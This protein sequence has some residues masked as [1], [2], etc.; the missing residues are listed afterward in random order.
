MVTLLFES[1]MKEKTAQIKIF[2]IV[3][4]VLII[5]S[6]LLFLGATDITVYVT[7]SG[8][9]YHR[10][11]CGSL[12][13]SKIAVTLEDAV[14]SGYTP[15]SVCEPPVLSNTAEPNHPGELYRVNTAN[16]AKTRDAQTARMVPAEVMGHID[17]DTVRVRISN[18]HPDLKTL[19]TIRMIGVDTPETVHPHKPVEYFGQEASNFTKER[20]LG[21]Q[22]YLAFDW[23]LRDHYGRLLA[24]IYTAEGR[25]FNRILIQEGYG[26]AYISYPF[27]FKD[28]FTALEHAARTSKR[29]LWGNTEVPHPQ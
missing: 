29:G 13:R 7:N 16:L 15:C 19:E 14:H 20:L 6:S 9:K 18:P 27:Q 2:C 1:K 12:S 4:S 24:Y 26:Y 17:G 28:E 11:D 3:R 23:D 10:E 8:K 22:V 5:V 25:C 21:Q